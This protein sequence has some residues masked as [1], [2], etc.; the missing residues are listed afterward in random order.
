MPLIYNS[1]ECEH[2]PVQEKVL[3]LVPH[4]CEI[5]DYGTVQNVL[6][7]NVAVSLQLS[8]FQQGRAKLQILFTKTRIL[9]IKVQTLECFKAM[10]KT[11]D[12][13]T[14]TTK[15]VPLLAKIKTKGESRLLMTN[16]LLTPSEP[17]VMVCLPEGHVFLTDDRWLL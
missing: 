1:L 9:S 2:M 7:V 12:K 14:L 16:A 3:K 6:L 5:L 17:A 11:L 8:Y 13:A 10:V 4:L 15:L